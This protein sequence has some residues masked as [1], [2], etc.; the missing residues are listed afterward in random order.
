MKYRMSNS[1]VTM[2]LNALAQKFGVTVNWNSE[3]L[4]PYMQ[5][6]CDKCVKYELTKNIKFLMFGIILIIAG[7][8]VI[9][10]L[11]KDIA[12]DPDEEILPAE[13]WGLLAVFALISS[14]LGAVLV[15][16]GLLNVVTCLTFPEKVTIKELQYIYSEIQNFK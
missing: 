9:K 14:V 6:L 16:C 15:G 3:T 10:M 5:Q 8:W 1:E 2:V 13:V 11:M 12:N 4:I 7:L